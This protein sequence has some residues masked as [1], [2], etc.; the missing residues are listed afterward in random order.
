M[1]WCRPK[2]GSVHCSQIV[3]GERT[4]ARRLDG[5]GMALV[6]ADDVLLVVG[7]SAQVVGDSSYRNIHIIL[8]IFTLHRH[9][10]CAS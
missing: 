10:T 3:V 7:N 4:L 5:G 2:L 6:S 8:S 9:I 1:C